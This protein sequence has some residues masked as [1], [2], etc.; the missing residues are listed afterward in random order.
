[1]K[2]GRVFGYRLGRDGVHYLFWYDGIF[3]IQTK[4]TPMDRRAYIFT[5]IVSRTSLDGEFWV[6]CGPTSGTKGRGHGYPRMS[7]NGQTVAVHRVVWVN[8]HGYLPGRKQID[9]TCRNRLC[10][11]PDHLEMVTHLTNQR[12]RDAANRRD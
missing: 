10:V 12:R 8:R 1:M 2:D 11:N 6:W 3:V 7:L 4:V 9:H 5:A